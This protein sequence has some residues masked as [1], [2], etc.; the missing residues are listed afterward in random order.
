LNPSRQIAFNAALT[1]LGRAIPFVVALVTVPVTIREFGLERF[2]V[3]ALVWALLAQLS[4]FDFGVGKACTALVAQAVGRGEATKTGSVVWT[5]VH[6]QLAFGIAGAV[7]TVLAAPIGVQWL[8]MPPALSS[9]AVT[10]FQLTGVSLPF[11]IGAIGLRG[12]L[13]GLQRFDVVGAIEA[14]SK[15]AVL[16]VPAFGAAIGWDLPAVGIALIVS[17]AAAFAC[18]VYACGRFVPGFSG[19]WRFRREEAGALL[20]FGRWIAMTSVVGPLMMYLDRWVIGSMLGITAVAFYTT[21]FDLVFRLSVLSQSVIAALFPALS[22]LYA[23]RMGEAAS[24]AAAVATRFVLIAVGLIGSV[25]ILLARDLLAFWLGPE[26]ARESSTVLQV[27]TVGLILNSIARIPYATVQAVG[28]P[29]V[30]A[31]FHVAELPFYVAILAGATRAWGL[32][33]AAVA[34]TVRVAADGVLLFVAQRRLTAAFTP[35]VRVRLGR[36]GVLVGAAMIAAAVV[37]SAAP[38]ATLRLATAA[39]LL[40]V[41]AAAGHQ[42]VLD[43]HDRQLLRELVAKGFATVAR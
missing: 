23:M 11:T 13:E 12:G 33:G 39:S 29:D 26:F 37:A 5:A 31:K 21:P 1:L 19:A 9:E 16:I 15:S 14:A 27:L 24:H 17:Q 4:F 36:G 25:V 28:R 35:D 18:Y 40:M 34:W 41:G 20:R 7:T 30:T 22:T 42:L 6:I 2:G 32:T 43:G 10:I 38:S 8:T 3:L